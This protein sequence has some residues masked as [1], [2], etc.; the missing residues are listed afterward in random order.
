MHP[1]CQAIWKEHCLQYFKPGMTVLEAGPNL[2]GSWYK[3]NHPDGKR[4]I[5]ETVDIR[6]DRSPTGRLHD[7][8]HTGTAYSYPVPTN[9]YDVVLAVMVAEHVPMPW[10]W[11]PELARCCKVGGRVILI[12]PFV[13]QEHGDQDYWRFLP[14]GLRV[15]AEEAGLEVC[16]A[17]VMDLVP[18]DYHVDC[19]L[20]ARKP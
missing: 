7:V 14:R 6:E 5:W 2:S 12:A 8:T 15:L 18:D 10:E 20:I 9:Y 19:L 17:E 3:N 13:G 16:K 11:M 1:N 4:L